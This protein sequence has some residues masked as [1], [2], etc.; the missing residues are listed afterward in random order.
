VAYERNLDQVRQLYYPDD[1]AGHARIL[2]LPSSARTA[3]AAWLVGR[4]WGGKWYK[5]ARDA[6]TGLEYWHRGAC[7][8]RWIE[9]AVGTFLVSCPKPRWTAL[10]VLQA[11]PLEIDENGGR[12]EFRDGGED[13]EGIV[14]HTTW[15]NL[16]RSILLPK[17]HPDPATSGLVLGLR[18]PGRHLC[19]RE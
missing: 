13:C 9:P 10:R 5:G 3:L 11:L 1:A 8:L 15:P 14:I 17:G 7:L 6:S 2:A 12:T 19:L 16:G 18:M 4:A